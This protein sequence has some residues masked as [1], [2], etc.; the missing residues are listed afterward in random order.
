[1]V[2]GNAYRHKLPPGPLGSFTGILISFKVV[3]GL[4]AIRLRLSHTPKLTSVS[5]H[6]PLTHVRPGKL[7]YHNPRVQEVLRVVLYAS[8]YFLSTIILSRYGM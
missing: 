1:M 5:M 6:D 3:L 8:G 7:L 2:S 4:K